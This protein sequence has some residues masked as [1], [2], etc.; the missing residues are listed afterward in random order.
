[1]IIFGS[2]M[3]PYVRKTCAYANEKGLDFELKVVGIGDPD[4]EFVAASPWRKMPAMKDGDFMLADSSAIIHYLEAKYPEPELVPS[5]PEERG[6]T[7]WWD[8]W[9]DTIVGMTIGKMFFNRIVSPMFL[10]REGDAAMAD[11]A[12]KEELPR[13]L[14]YLEGE[15]PDSGF[16]VGDRLTLADL[17]VAAPF[18]NLAHLGI[19]I[20]EKRWAKSRAYLNAMLSRDS[21][22]TMIAKESRF[23]ERARAEATA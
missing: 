8:E 20:D 22:A 9:A 15:I 13:L 11:A 12:E 2:T 4:P 21:Y 10:K 3:S 16:L 17:A 5:D 18:A 14:D 7:I 1:M 23:F 19:A 6:R